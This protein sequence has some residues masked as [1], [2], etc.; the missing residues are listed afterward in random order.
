M[1]AITISHGSFGNVWLHDLQR[2]MGD[3]RAAGEHHICCFWSIPSALLL[4]PHSFACDCGCMT[5]NEPWVTCV[6]QVNL[7]KYMNLV[8][9]VAFL[10]LG[11]FCA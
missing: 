8:L 2:A 9:P 5:F 10:L 4:L 3:M 1:I 7:A 6:L 11:P